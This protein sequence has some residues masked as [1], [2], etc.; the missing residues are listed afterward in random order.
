MPCTGS[1]QWFEGG[2]RWPGRQVTEDRR[3]WYGMT[4]EAGRTVTGYRA[5]GCTVSRTGWSQMTRL[6]KA[7]L[8]GFDHCAGSRLVARS[9]L[10]F[11]SR[12]DMPYSDIHTAFARCDARFDVT[13]SA[14]AVPG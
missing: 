6:E 7:E 12:S 9:S 8:A 13:A 11:E 14:L 1:E 3:A 4:P 2:P 10:R 5:S